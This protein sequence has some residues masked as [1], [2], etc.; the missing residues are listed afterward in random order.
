MNSRSTKV[1][2]SDCWFLQSVS[3]ST[4]DHCDDMG[5]NMEVNFEMRMRD[6]LFRGRIVVAAVC[7]CILGAILLNTPGV[8][9]RQSIS[10]FLLAGGLLF[11]GFAARRK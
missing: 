9:Q 6:E 4:A 3:N 11:I 5:G 8:D 1:D 2:K 7:A 10:A